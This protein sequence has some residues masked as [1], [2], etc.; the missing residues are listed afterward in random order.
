MLAEKHV[1][2]L[3]ELNDI[4][5]LM[6]VASINSSKILLSEDFTYMAPNS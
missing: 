5:N 2:A 3:I 1:F 4:L 6:V